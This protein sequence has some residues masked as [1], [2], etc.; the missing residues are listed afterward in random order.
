[1]V[2]IETILSGGCLVASSKTNLLYYAKKKLIINLSSSFNIF[3]NQFCKIIKNY[4]KI[5]NVKKNAINFSKK[6]NVKD[7]KNALED[8]Y[9]F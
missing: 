8:L 5:N 7:Y 6:V 2:A 3:C 9:N 1:M 4:K